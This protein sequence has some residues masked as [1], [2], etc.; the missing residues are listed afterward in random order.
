MIASVLTD[1]DLHPVLLSAKV[2]RIFT[3]KSS[4]S[5]AISLTYGAKLVD[6]KPLIDKSSYGLSVEMHNAFGVDI[7]ELHGSS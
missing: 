5:L 7:V 4:L 2:M 1:H 6:C 3:G